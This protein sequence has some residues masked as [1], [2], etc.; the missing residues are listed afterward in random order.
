MGLMEE[1]S[2][3][4]LV[5]VRSPTFCPQAGP[6]LPM[7]TTI[8]STLVS[9]THSLVVRRGAEPPRDSSRQLSTYLPALKTKAF[10]FVGDAEPITATDALVGASIQ[11]AF[12]GASAAPTRRHSW[13][14]RAIAPF[15]N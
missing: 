1:C 9:A 11:S 2:T 6:S 10:N 5:P 14:P 7:A 3:S 8:R 4:K 12:P 13:Q 15:R